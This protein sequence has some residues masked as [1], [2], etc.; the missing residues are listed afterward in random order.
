MI[1]ISVLS[2][3]FALNYMILLRILAKPC[4]YVTIF[5]VVCLMCCGII[6]MSKR[7]QRTKEQHDFIVLIIL[8]VFFVVTVCLILF[9]RK[10]IALACQII[11]E[12]SKY[13]SYSCSY[14]DTLNIFR[15]VTDTLSTLVF[16]IVPWLLGF[17]VIVFSFIV[18]LNL[19]SIY[20][21]VWRVDM[22][23]S[24]NEVCVCDPKLNYAHGA[25]CER[26]KF[27]NYCKKNGT[28]D[29]CVISACTLKQEVPTEVHYFQVVNFVGCYWLW[30]FVSGFGEMVLAGTFATWYWTYDKSKVPFFTI[31]T[32]MHRTIR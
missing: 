29:P 28:Q 3:V 20:D 5:I 14:I 16:P 7:Y 4:I 1:V 13:V 11:E 17:F 22:I 15:A 8:G 18:W 32:S 23:D 19:L 27:N 9:L 24:K 2:A 31:T 26:D 6:G 21:T 10:R 25:E 12:A 30:F